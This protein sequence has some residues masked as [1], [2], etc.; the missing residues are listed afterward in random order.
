MKISDLTPY[1]RQLI[2]LGARRPRIS[3]RD[4]FGAPP[5]LIPKRDLPIRPDVDYPNHDERTPQG[6]AY[7]QMWLDHWDNW[8]NTKNPIAAPMESGA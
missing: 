8:G 7:T 4:I 5:P 3:L 6:Q 1:A 2:K